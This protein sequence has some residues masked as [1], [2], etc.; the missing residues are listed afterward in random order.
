MASRPKVVCT[1]F[2]DRLHEA[3][4]LC[5][6][7]MVALVSTILCLRHQAERTVGLP[8]GM[9]FLFRGDSSM[10]GTTKGSHSYL[11]QN[12][13]APMKRPR[14]EPTWNPHGT[15]LDAA[16]ALCTATTHTATV[17]LTPQLPFRK[18]GLATQLET[19]APLALKPTP[20]ACN[21]GHSERSR[22]F[23]QN[24]ASAHRSGSNTGVNPG[25]ADALALFAVTVRPGTLPA[26]RSEIHLGAIAPLLFNCD[27]Q[28]YCFAEPLA[29]SFFFPPFRGASAGTP[30]SRR[31]SSSSACQRADIS[32]TRSG[33][34]A[35][36]LVSSLRSLARL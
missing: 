22:N 21:T 12:G 31:Y 18:T 32:R 25:L 16:R 15:R 29:L 20:L 35:A 2:T 7:D 14:K 8:V 26:A 28:V 13:E 6:G 24:T 33:F 36:R 30:D 9:R 19:I 4:V 10:T 3:L 34:L 11:N 23:A 27:S 17:R 5:H 1:R